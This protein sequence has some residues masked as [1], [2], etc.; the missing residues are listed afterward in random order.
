MSGQ[1]LSVSCFQFVSIHNYLIQHVIMFHSSN[2][3]WIVIIYLCI[4]N[5]IKQRQWLLDLSTYILIFSTVKIMSTVPAI[6]T[7]LF[8]SAPSLHDSLWEGTLSSSD[9]SGKQRSSCRCLSINLAEFSSASASAAAG[10]LGPA[11]DGMAGLPLL[12][13]LQIKSIKELRQYIIVNNLKDRY[14]QARKL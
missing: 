9:R 10:L 14:Y 13:Y 12:I 6:I 11:L 5:L 2:L 8:S 7:T 3:S 4:S 1:L